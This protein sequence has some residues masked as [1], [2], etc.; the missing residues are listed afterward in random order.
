MTKTKRGSKSGDA[1]VDHQEC[2][3]RVRQLEEENKAFQVIGCFF[4]VI[5]DD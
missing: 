1:V 3:S 5:L 4:I 2:G